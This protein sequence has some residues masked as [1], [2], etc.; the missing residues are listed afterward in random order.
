GEGGGRG[1]GGTRGGEADCLRHDGWGHGV[2]FSPDGRTLAASTAAGTV[3]LWD[4]TTRKVRAVLREETVPLGVSVAF[5]PDGAT[6]ASAS[7]DGA[8][9]L[10]GVA[11]GT[12]P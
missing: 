2:A 6:L 3:E 10:G 4:L 8:V 11:P 9:R 1:G 7:A 12:G 5:S